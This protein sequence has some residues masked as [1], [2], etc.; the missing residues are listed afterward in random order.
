[1]AQIEMVSNAQGI[2][3]DL[4]RFLAEAADSAAITCTTLCNFLELHDDKGVHYA[5]LKLLAYAQAV[6]GGADLLISKGEKP[7]P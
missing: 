7:A 2:E 3:D 6:K 5:A 1:M 4:R